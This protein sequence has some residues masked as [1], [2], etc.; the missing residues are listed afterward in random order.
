MGSMGGRYH[1]ATSSL[2]STNQVPT[3]VPRR[4][5]SMRP[6]LPHLHLYLADLGKTHQFWICSE[7]SQHTRYPALSQ[8]QDTHCVL[9]GSR[10]EQRMNKVAGD[11]ERPAQPP[12]HRSTQGLST[13]HVLACSLVFF[14]ASPSQ[15]STEHEDKP[16]R[17]TVPM[18]TPF[19]HQ[20]SRVQPVQARPSSNP[21][22]FSAPSLLSCR[23]GALLT[24]QRAS[25]SVLRSFP[26][27][28]CCV[29]SCLPLLVLLLVLLP[30]RAATSGGPGRLLGRC[31]PTSPF[32]LSASDRGRLRSSHCLLAADLSI[33]DNEHS[34]RLP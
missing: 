26:R 31:G 3:T 5:C 12:S 9:G 8:K 33:I 29:R 21:S 14:C 23:A 22:I 13:V 28:R 25:C 15:V 24:S 10:W 34:D 16:G 20:P 1:H 7:R 17:S 32:I 11:T 4:A 6:V 19:A 30:A 2:C 18:W 27:C